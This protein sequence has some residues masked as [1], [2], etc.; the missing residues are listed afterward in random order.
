[1][2]VDSQSETIEFLA[3]PSA[4]GGGVT[5][6]ERIDTH[7][8]VVFLAG[9]R[10]YKLKRAVRFDYVDFGTLDRRREACEAELRL[11][12]R[13]CP[14]LYLGLKPVV[15]TADGTLAL[16]VDGDVVEWLVEMA[17]LDQ[18]GLFNRLAE[19]GALSEPLIREV[20]DAVAQL[21]AAADRR[22]AHGGREGMAWV[23][24][25]NLDEFESLTGRP[26]D[27]GDVTRYWCLAEAALARH[28][29]L[30]EARRLS[31]FV[32]ECHGDLHLR[33]I[34]LFDGRSVLFDAVEFNDAI[35]CCDVMY[36]FAFLAMDLLHRDLRSLANA[37]FNRY[38]AMTGDTG[39]LAPFR[40]FLSCRAAVRA[41]TSA[42]AAAAQGDPSEARRLSDDAAGYLREAC[43][44]L[45][46]DAPR[47][48]AVGGFSGTG[49]STLAAAIAPAL[50]A[51]PGALV[52]RSDVVRKRLFGLEPCASLGPAG[53]TEKVTGEVYR[54][55]VEATSEALGAGIAVIADAVFARPAER[56]AIAAAAAGAGAP[57]DGLWLEAPTDVMAARVRGRVDGPSDADEA[58]LWRQL[59]YETGTIAWRRID[60]AGPAETLAGAVA[61]ALAA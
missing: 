40:F 49:K 30:L 37:A 9:E 6:V 10:A 21:H 20:A 59:A 33:N 28:G 42:R 54:R 41:K 3:S 27:P 5:A 61:A 31:G 22:P 19:R 36:D 25:G 46:P 4:Y 58:V 18:S 11:N 39:G 53:Y 45:A 15:R 34:C 2:S 47:L 24:S 51:P 43:A 1:M 52:L 16:G 13:T 57:F 12:R 8:S 32:R 35:A 26:F 29:A 17:R 14:E 50:G 7:I 55:I 23:V 48:V 56:E 44:F 38:L 60:A